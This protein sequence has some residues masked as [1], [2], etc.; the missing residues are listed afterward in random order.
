MNFIYTKASLLSERE[1]VKK[2][3]A[4]KHA[5]TGWRKKFSMKCKMLYYML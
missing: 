4:G 3:S 5:A 2:K 1:N